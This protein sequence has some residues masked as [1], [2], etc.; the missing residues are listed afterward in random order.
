MLRLYVIPSVIEALDCSGYACIRI[1]EGLWSGDV[2]NTIE[3][4]HDKM[5]KEVKVLS[6]HKDQDPG[7][8]LV[9]VKKYPEF[10]RSVV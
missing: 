9:T 7:Y 6:I 8:L 1:Q 2:G 10:T 3:I 4:S 5:S